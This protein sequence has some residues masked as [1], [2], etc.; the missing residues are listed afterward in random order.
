MDD[1]TTALNIDCIEH[2]KTL[3]AN[4][5]DLAVCDPMY[6]MKR[7]NFAQGSEVSTTGYTRKHLQ[8]AKDL[9]ETKPVNS[10]W[11]NELVRISRNQIIWGINTFS[12]VG[13]VGSGR[14]IWDKINDQ[15]TFSHA[16]IASCSMI[17]GVRIFRYLWNGMIQQKMGSRKQEK[18]H[19]FQ[20]PIELYEWI[21]TNFATPSTIIFDSHMGSGSSRIAAYNLGL[22]YVGCEI[23]TQHFSNA[24]TRFKNHVVA[25]HEN[26]GLFP[27]IMEQEVL[28]K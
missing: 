22:K 12:F 26:P 25:R 20:K 11:Y 14:L 24:E 16:E 9:G 2:M 6:V 7:Q 10:D 3:P 13:D 27:T 17:D 15:S 4:S 8:A 23:N 18:I 28:F 19:P 1:S 5:Y 21:Y